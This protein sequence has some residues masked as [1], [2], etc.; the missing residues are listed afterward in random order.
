M[1]KGQCGCGA[2]TYSM[3]S[4][5]IC[6]HCCHCS[7][8][9][10]QTGSAFVL[11]AIIEA[12]RVEFDGPIVENTL[13]TPSGKGQVITRCATCGVAVFSSYMARLGKLRYIRVGTLDNPSDCPPDVQIFTSS[14][15]DWVQLNTEIPVF[16]DF[17]DFAE[18]WPEDALARWNTLFGENA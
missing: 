8:C 12:D 16:E 18:V 4:K 14:K 9:Q 13:P 1:L 11:N 6:V 5:P 15:Q 10:K 17:Y 2:V 7:E 3:S